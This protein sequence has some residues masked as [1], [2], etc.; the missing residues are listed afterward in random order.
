MGTRVGVRWSWGCQMGVS[1]WEGGREI[2]TISD[3]FYMND[4]FAFKQENEH[5]LRSKT[6]SACLSLSLLQFINRFRAANLTKATSSS[7]VEAKSS[8]DNLSTVILQGIEAFFVWSQWWRWRR[9]TSNHHIAATTA[10]AVWDPTHVASI[11][12]RKK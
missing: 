6:I 4:R 12:S 2:E 1:W 9:R 3:K 8:D 5:I 10:G 11:F 7:S